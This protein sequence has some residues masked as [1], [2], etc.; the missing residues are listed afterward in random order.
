VLLG[1]TVIGA[2][3]F[4]VELALGRKPVSMP[5]AAPALDPA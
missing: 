1:L 2:V 4:H 5:A 3:W